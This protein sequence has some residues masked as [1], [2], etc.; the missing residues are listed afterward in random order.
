MNESTQQKIEEVKR[1]LAD[2][3]ADARAE[4]IKATIACAI[5]HGGAP[6]SLSGYG[7]G[8]GETVK[9][10]G[11]DLTVVEEQILRGDN[12]EICVDFAIDAAGY[13]ATIESRLR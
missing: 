8:L 1:R 6:H 2:M 10:N 3:S 7:H 12:G 13:I 4:V 11:R 5:P 9:A